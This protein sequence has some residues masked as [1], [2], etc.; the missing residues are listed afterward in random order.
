METILR[1]K[2]SVGYSDDHLYINNTTDQSE[3]VIPGNRGLLSII[4]TGLS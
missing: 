3:S 4:I 1:N 2:M